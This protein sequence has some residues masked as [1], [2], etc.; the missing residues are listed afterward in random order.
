M[1]SPAISVIVPVYG[2]ERYIE[3]CLRSIADQTFRDFEL[4]LVD[5]GSKDRSI[6][7]AREYLE[8]TALSWRILR[9]ENQ[10][11]AAAR[12]AGIGIARG[13]WISCIDSDDTVSSDFLEVLYNTAREAK[14]DVSVVDYLYVEDGGDIPADTGEGHIRVFSKEEALHGFLVRTFAPV[15]PAFLIR[16]SLIENA[17][18]V[19]DK[20]CRFSEDAFY[21]WQVFFSAERVAVSDR[22]LYFYLHRPNSIMTS[23]K[24]ANILTGYRA[25]QSL[26]RNHQAV[27]DFFPEIH[28]LLP[29]WVLGALHSAAKISDYKVFCRL[30]QD[31]DYRSQMQRLK[32]FPERKARILSGMLRLSPLVFYKFIQVMG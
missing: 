17:H 9:Q 1:P 20:N 32:G 5:D 16:K 4:I 31:M 19:N 12:E 25:I 18:I 2:V 27:K 11:L 24:S 6:D 14:V 21:L 30:A 10:G 13:E 22:K 28:Y 3:A 29:R 15:L 23:A 8:T 26:V 7:I